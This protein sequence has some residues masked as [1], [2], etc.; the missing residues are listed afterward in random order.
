M[1]EWLFERNILAMFFGAIRIHL[2]N[3]DIDLLPEY[4]MWFPSISFHFPSIFI[5]SLNFIARFPS[6]LWHSRNVISANV[7]FM[8]PGPSISTTRELCYFPA[9]RWATFPNLIN[10]IHV[11]TEQ[12][13]GGHRIWISMVFFPEQSTKGLSGSFESCDQW[14][15]F[16]HRTI[17]ALELRN[18]IFGKICRFTIHQTVET[19]SFSNG[20]CS[21]L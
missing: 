4:S 16:H 6:W 14:P 2:C 12:W 9:H 21:V 18:C 15:S 5:A 3:W 17:W 13:Y 10:W 19:F 8:C 11:S 20:E 7:Y 1:D